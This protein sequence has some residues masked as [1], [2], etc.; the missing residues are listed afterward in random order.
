MSGDFVQRGEPLPFSLNTYGPRP[1]LLCGADLVLELPAGFF[2]QCGIF[3]GGA[4]SLLNGSGV[5]DQLCFGSEEGSVEGMQLAARILNEEPQGF[6][7]L[8]KNSLKQGMSFSRS[9]KPGSWQVSC[10]LHSLSEKICPPFRHP[11]SPLPIIFWESNTAAPFSDLTAP[12][13]PVTLKR[14]GPGIMTSL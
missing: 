11:F 13:K 2:C 10:T 8:L 12:L 7:D 6:R 5:V 9:Q 3:A 4:V 1:P 14:E